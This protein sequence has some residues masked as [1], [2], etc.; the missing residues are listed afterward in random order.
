MNSSIS[1]NR[2]V[3]PWNARDNRLKFARISAFTKLS[4]VS[5]CICI[6][7][8]LSENPSV[9]RLSSGK[10]LSLVL[11][12]AVNPVLRC[13]LLKVDQFS[14]LA[15]YSKSKQWRSQISRS[16]RLDK[17]LRYILRQTEGTLR[18]DESSKFSFTVFMTTQSCTT[19]GLT[20][21]RNLRAMCRNLKNNSNEQLP[22]DRRDEFVKCT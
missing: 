21:T 4:V 9:D 5:K 12:Y 6:T 14:R 3:T 17:F 2:W 20:S 10:K 7:L 1:S 16:R 18:E 11:G 22:V 19:T 15:R 8:A 13:R